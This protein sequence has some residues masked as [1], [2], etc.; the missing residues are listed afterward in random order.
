[1]KTKYGKVL[2]TA[3]LAAALC[4]CSSGGGKPVILLD[5]GHDLQE[6]GYTAYD[7]DLELPFVNYEEGAEDTGLI[8]E[9]AYDEA[10]TAELESLLKATGQFTV[11]RMKDA[12]DTMT[13][14][15]RLEKIDKENPDLVVSIHAIHT[16]EQGATAPLICVE[17]PASNTHDAS[18]AAGSALQAHL[19]PAEREARLVYCYYTPVR[20]ETWQLHLVPA[21]D[22]TDY[23]EET[24]EIMTGNSAP[25]VQIAMLSMHSH[26]DLGALASAEG[27]RQTAEMIRDGLTDYFADQK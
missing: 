8:T 15:R 17:P 6:T 26:E 22:T 11:V 24:L 25:V 20:P 2:L 5:A 23:G 27:I 7:P 21:D 9:A 1:M 14:A 3:A 19:Y 16:T 4:G 18:F 10:L 12:D 13:M